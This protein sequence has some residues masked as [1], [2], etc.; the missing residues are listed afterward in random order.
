M[1]SQARQL[2]AIFALACSTLIVELVLTRAY[3]LVFYYHFS[4]IAVSM[5]MLGLSAGSVLLFLRPQWNTAARV[6]SSVARCSAALAVSM[7]ACYV[8]QIHVPHVFRP[9]L[10]GFAATCLFLLLVSI[11]FVLSGLAI[12]MLLTR[13]GASTSA[14]YAA[15]LA[16]AATG[17][18]AVPLLLSV[19]DP[20]TAVF[21]AATMAAAVAW[22]LASGP[23]PLLLTLALAGTTA[24]L[25]VHGGLSFPYVKG[26]PDIPFEYVG[27]NSFSRVTVSSQGSMPTWLSYWN[28]PVA[29]SL[30][31][32][33]DANAGTDIIHSSGNFRELQFLA[34][35][36]TNLV[37]HLRSHA[38]VLILGCGGGKDAATALSFGNTDVTAIEMNNLIVGL[39]NGRYRK[40]SGNL[41][42]QARVVW[43][44]AR[45]YLRDDPNRYDIIQMSMIDTTAAVASGA[46]LLTEHSLYTV[47]A[48]TTILAHLK[49]DGIFT[50]TRNRYHGWPLEVDR[51]LALAVEALRRLGVRDPR[52]HVA[53]FTGS[54]K[55]VNDPN[56]PTGLTTILVSRSPWSDQDLQRMKDLEQFRFSESDAVR[57]NLEPDREKLL[58]PAT[59]EAALADAPLDISAPVDDRPFFFFHIKPGQLLSGNYTALIYHQSILILPQLLV[60]VTL[61]SAVLLGAPLLGRARRPGVRL[62]AYFGAI[63]VAF[64]A[65][66]VALLQV[67]SIY[68]GHP[69]YSMVVVLFSLLL[70]SGVGSLLSSR[71]P[72]RLVLPALC[73]LLLLEMLV[74]PPILAL[75]GV[76]A[77]GRVGVSLLL[78]APLGCLMGMA[79][80]LGLGEVHRREPESAA[81]CWAVN[82]A[83]SV[84]TSVITLLVALLFGLRSIFAVGLLAY[85]LAAAL[86]SNLTRNQNEAN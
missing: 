68:L 75:S 38:K 31:V 74:Y 6:E 85:A 46:Y 67:L 10:G 63:G 50:V 52:R 73:G 28:G 72:S 19:T 7:G 55:A 78:T 53:L 9:G 5:A 84:F 86:Y 16:G 47:E 66:E 56:A 34:Y 49:P 36:I 12:A 15:D 21:T 18:L 29:D 17:C 35:D 11:P 57:G 3:S 40:Y 54:Y 26:K 2:L 45:S 27:W 8:A 80:P 79:F 30:N 44:E 37:Y 41:V 70:A 39:L 13:P 62:S 23:G 77:L 61:L 25:G 4:F 42:Q 48:W 60:G 59:Y 43:N 58:D 81:W 64:M 33:I 24:G 32:R 82:G 20:S 71:L 69:L 76:N 22:L 83:A 14:L 1:S 65:V 51:S